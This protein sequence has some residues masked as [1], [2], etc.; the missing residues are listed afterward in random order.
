MA[1]AEKGKVIGHGPCPNCG[2]PAAY[3]LNKKGRVYV[4]CVVEADG[5]CHSGTQSRSLKG[6]QKLAARI[7]KWS[8]TDTRNRLLGDGAPPPV[9]PDKPKTSIWDKELF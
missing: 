7:A 4:Y 9:T 5:G 1:D 2:A 6:D 8:C 3:K